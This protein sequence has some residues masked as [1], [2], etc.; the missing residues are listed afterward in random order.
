M[1]GTELPLGPVDVQAW[2]DTWLAGNPS[3]QKYVEKLWYIPQGK[4]IPTDVTQTIMLASAT[5]KE[6]HLQVGVVVKPPYAMTLDM[7]LAMLGT[8]P[9]A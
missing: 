3:A 4:P 1:S 2:L 6:R 5:S 9:K 8:A 7:L